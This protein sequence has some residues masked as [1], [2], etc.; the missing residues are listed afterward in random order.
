MRAIL[1]LVTL[2]ALASA[3]CA[4]TYTLPLSCS[5]PFAAG[6]RWTTTADFGVS[7]LSISSVSIDWSGD[8]DIG[9]VTATFRGDGT[10]IMREAESTSGYFDVVQPFQP[11]LGQS[12]W[13]FLLDGRATL[14]I[15]FSTIVG[16]PENPPPPQPHYHMTSAALVLEGTPV[17]EPASALIL[18]MGLGAVVRRR[19]WGGLTDDR[20]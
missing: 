11:Y 3:A 2:V 18:L 12:S 4:T 20:A 13:A 19:R 1:S 15:D 6:A 16:I 14:N 8:A 5:G 9:R 17:P 7:F 10:G